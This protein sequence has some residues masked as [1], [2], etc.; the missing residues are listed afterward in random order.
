MEITSAYLVMS[1]VLTIR[2]DRTQFFRYEAFTLSCAVPGHFT[3]WRV[4][5][6]TSTGSFVPCQNNWGRPNGSLC[7]NR[8]VFS[9]DSG[10]YW[11][12]SERECS[13]VLNITVDTGVVILESPALSVTVGDKVILRCSYREI[14]AQSSSSDFNATFYQNGTF[15]GTLPQGQMI[16][17]KVSKSSEGF[18]KCQ[19]PTKGESPQS[20]LSVKGDEA[21]APPVPTPPL[22]SLPSLVCTILLF[23]LYTG[24]LMLCV[25]TYRKWARA[26]ADA[27]RTAPDHL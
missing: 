8:K 17:E 19:H 25:H 26:R 3:G 12:E 5:R 7:M 15:I 9:S 21:K 16:I 13:N 6:N 20:W 18:Y 24:I 23:I 27:K 1:A 4:K 11:C 10:Q 2:P 22:M 14:W